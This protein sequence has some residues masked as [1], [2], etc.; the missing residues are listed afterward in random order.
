VDGEIS[1]ANKPETLLDATAGSRV[2]LDDAGQTEQARTTPR[3]P[4]QQRPVT[5]M[6]PQTLRCMPQGDIELMSKEEIPDFQP[7]P[8]LEQVSDKRP[9]QVKDGKH[10]M[11]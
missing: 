6:Q 7:P 8:R 2:R 3:H 4:R 1:S 5:I 10:L 9:K 11:R